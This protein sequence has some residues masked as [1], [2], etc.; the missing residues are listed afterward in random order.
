MRALKPSNEAAIQIAYPAI[1]PV[2]QATPAIRDFTLKRII[3]TT[4][5][6][7]TATA[8][9]KTPISPKKSPTDI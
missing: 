6:P 7:G 3:C 9:A 2:A 1:I 4:S 5:G 8:A